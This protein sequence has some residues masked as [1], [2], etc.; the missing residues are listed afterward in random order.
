MKKCESHQHNGIKEK[1]NASGEYGAQVEAVSKIFSLLGDN[2]RMKILLALME[3]EL[4]VYHICEITGAKQ[5]AT[6]QHLKKLKDGKIIKSRKEANQV[7]Y[8][9]ADEHVAS[10]IKAAL[11]HRHC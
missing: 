4:C 6:S 9:I 10:I 3:G 7:L 2:S 5:S 1:L 11:Q 8:S